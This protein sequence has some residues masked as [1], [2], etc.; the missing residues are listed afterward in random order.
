M[1]LPAAAPFPGFA[2]RRVAG[3]A[4]GTLLLA[5]LAAAAMRLGFVIGSGPYAA[6]TGYEEFCLYNI[7]KVTAGH[8]LY[9]WPHRD[10]YLL[11][12]YNAGFYHAYALWTKLWQAEGAA[13][14]TAARLLTPLG[15]LGGLAVQVWLAHRLAPAEAAAQ[16]A[17]VW[18]LAFVTWFGAFNAWMP[19][20]ARPDIPAVA[21]A[22]TGLAV[23]L[24]AHERK[25]AVLWAA[26]SLLFFAAWSGK[27]S[28]VWIFT[29]TVLFALWTRAG[30][31]AL[32]GLVLPFTGLAAVFLVGGSAAYRFNLLET[33]ALFA[34]FPRQ[35]VELVGRTIVLNP[36]FFAGAAW[37]LAPR[38]GRPLPSPADDRARTATRACFFAAAPALLAGAGQLALQGSATN[39][40]LEGVTVTAVLGSAAWLRALAR[41]GHDRFVAFGAG[42]LFL[43]AAPPVLQLAGALR[44]AAPFTLAGASL[45]NVVKLTPAQLAARREFAAAMERLPKPLWLRDAMLQLPWFATEGK[46]PA[47]VLNPQFEADARARGRLEGAGFAEWI[48]R[49]HFAS[50]LLRDDDPLLDAVRLAGY[51]PASTPALPPLP[52]E[53]G[54]PGPAPRLWLRDD[55]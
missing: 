53:F 7:W 5:S 47:F 19:F 50:L 42:C 37:L 21:L 49:R 16:R 12:F 20:S 15:A 52:T 45:G 55:R 11:T 6:T 22:L 14:V 1:S 43:M 54:L 2:A 35:S 46:Y 44:G 26:S 10:T 9:E 23:A 31:R 34:W 33:P 4:G 36:L 3:L 38:R 39:N 32:A 30:V 13:L 24:V 8:P 18:T 51:R 25:R 40:V 48:A 27:Q 29:G 28:I 17:W 41:G